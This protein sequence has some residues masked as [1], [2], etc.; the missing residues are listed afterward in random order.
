MADETKLELRPLLADLV[1]FGPFI[2]ETGFES[3]DRQ[4]TVIFR[5]RNTSEHF[6]IVYACDNT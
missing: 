2:F 1:D 4:S 3:F 5:K 6:K